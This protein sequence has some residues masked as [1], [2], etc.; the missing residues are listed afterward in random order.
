MPAAI[1]ILLIFLFIAGYLL[2]MRTFGRLPKGKDRV[3][4]SHS[5][6][7]HGKKFVN[8]SPAPMHI[9][10]GKVLKDYKKSRKNKKKPGPALP[11]K[12]LTRQNFSATPSHCLK[13]IWL[14]HSGVLIEMDGVRMIDP[15]LSQ[16][17]SPFTWAGVKRLHEAPLALNDLPL[18]DIILISHDHYDHLDYE[19]ILQFR[20]T[21]TRFIVPLGVGATLVYWG[22]KKENIHELDWSESCTYAGINIIALPSQHFSGR[23]LFS[24]DKTLWCSWAVKG[25]DSSLYHSGDSGYFPGYKD[26]GNTYG[27]FDL[28]CIGIGAYNNLWS[29]IHTSPEEAV[30]AHLDIKAKKLLPVHWG[31]FNMAFHSYTEPIE[32]L[33]NYAKMRG[34]SLLLPEIGEWVEVK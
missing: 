23:R 29:T 3:R 2:S 20:N 11:V 9:K 27:P 24:R 5:P 18:V 8:S 28:S 33:F 34:V 16:N 26:I 13:A 30:Q 22:I 15:M 17:A 21:K 25:R 7:F 19:T 10:P 1:V 32:R 4:I 31:T 6:H 14:G 12:K